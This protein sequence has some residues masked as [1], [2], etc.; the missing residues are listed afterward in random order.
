ML[1]EKGN[2]QSSEAASICTNESVPVCWLK[3][4]QS[5]SIMTQQTLY[6]NCF[7]GGDLGN[8]STV[9]EKEEGFSLSSFVPFEFEPCDCISNKK[10]KRQIQELLLYPMGK[11]F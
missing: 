2:E 6:C 8:C 7:R 11:I 4:T 5:I 9:N 10:K 3:Y 1:S